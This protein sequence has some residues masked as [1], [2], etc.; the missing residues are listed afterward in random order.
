MQSI[1][2]QQKYL[3]YELVSRDV[4]SRYVGSIIGLFW[5]I[6]NPLAQLVLYTLIFS[7]VLKVKLGPSDSTGDF[8]TSLFCA[9]LPWMAIQEAVTRSSRTFI[10]NHNLIRKVRFPIEVLPFSM[11]ASAFV[12]QFLGTGVFVLILIVNRS[13]NLEGFALIFILYVFQILL[14]YGSSM[15]VASLNV[16]FRDVAQILGVFFM[17]IFWG[18]PIVYPKERAPA[19]FRFILDLN[20]L[21]HMVEAYRY[22]MLGH[23]APA[24]W[25]L[26]YWIAAC[27]VIFFLGRFVLIRTRKEILD[28]V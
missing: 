18:T 21:T 8:A 2:L 4:K 12:H 14:M 28:L 11:V 22:V 9:L 16:F 19:V 10:E 24:T 3:I 15:L 13:L 17:L 25:G 5:S 20:P 27:V 7:V 26:L 6:L 23:P 1:L